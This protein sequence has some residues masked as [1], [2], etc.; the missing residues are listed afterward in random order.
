LSG[1]IPM[2]LQ[3]PIVLAMFRFFP[4]SIELRQ[5]SFLWASDL[6]SY[7]SIA[8]LPFNIPFYGSHISLFAL[9]MAASNLLYTHMTMKQQAQ[10]NQMPGMKFMMYFMPV[11]LLCFLNSYASGL[12]YYYCLSMFITFLQM[13]FIRRMINDEKV[14]ARIQENKKKPVKKSKFQ[15]RLEEMARRQQEIARQQAQQ[16]KRK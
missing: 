14:L 12:N 7:D 5:K 13:F 1:C 9:L 3:F 6:S 16:Q 10:N 4:A 2:L 11:M 8:D 15:I